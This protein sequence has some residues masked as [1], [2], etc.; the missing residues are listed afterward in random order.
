MCF[1]IKRPCVVSAHTKLVGAPKCSY[2]TESESQIV[3]TCHCSSSHRQCTSADQRTQPVLIS[4]MT[5]WVGRESR[6][7]QP[8]S[9]YAATSSGRSTYYGSKG[10]SKTMTTCLYREE[11]GTDSWVNFN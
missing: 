6:L 3:G 7:I 2:F 5:I 4:K 10:G 9:C 11:P 1:H 8:I